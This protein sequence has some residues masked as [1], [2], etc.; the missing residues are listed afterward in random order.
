MVFTRSWELKIVEIGS[1]S[2]FGCEEFNKYSRRARERWE[3]LVN[4]VRGVIGKGVESSPSETDGVGFMFIS[5]RELNDS[6]KPEN[7]ST[8][9]SSVLDIDVSAARKAKTEES[10]F[11]C[12]LFEIRNVFEEWVLPVHIRQAKEFLL[13]SEEMP[14]ILKS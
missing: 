8:V 3:L 4:L 5:V 10:F 12:Y 7:W 2:K 6:M 11:K 9:E 14:E 1:R 13:E